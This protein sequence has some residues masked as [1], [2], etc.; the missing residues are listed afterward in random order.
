MKKLLLFVALCVVKLTYAQTLND[1]RSVATGAWATLTTWETYDGT[2]WVAATVVPTATSAQAINIRTGH[3]VTIAAAIAGG[4]DQTTVDAGGTL[5]TSGTIALSVANGTGVDLTI[6]GTFGDL[7]TGG[8]TFTGTWQMGANGTFIKTTGSSSNNWQNAYQGGII[9]IPATAFWILRK[10][11]T[12]NPALST[13]T[14]TT[15]A[16]YPNLTIENNTGAAWT[17]PAGSSFT[18]TTTR[19]TVKGNLDIGG[20]GSNTV[21]FLSSN[22]F[23]LCILVQGNVTI[24]AGCNFRN[25]G[26]GIEIQGNLTA[27]GSM[28]YDAADGRQL[29]FSGSNTQ[30]VSGTGALGIY[31]LVLNKTG[32]GVTLNRSITVDNTATFTSGIV[33][34]TSTN[35][36][37]CAA[38]CI[39]SGAS[40][41]SFVSGPVRYLGNST[42]IYPIGKGSSYRPAEVG[43]YTSA[44]W[45]ET[46]NNGCSANCAATGYTGINGTWTQTITGTEGADPNP[47]YVSCAEN[48]YTAGGC[49]TGC[50]GASSTATLASLH[51]GSAASV[52]GDAGAAYFSGG[53]CGLLACPTTDRRIESPTINCTGIVNPVVS[54]TYIENGSGTTDNA[55][56]WYFDGSTWAQIADM[57]K[58]SLCGVQGLWT[59]FSIA[60]PG[61]ASNNANVKIGFRW[62]NNDDGVGTDPSFAV[63]NLTVG[64][65]EYFTAE[66]FPANPQ[67]TFN[68]VLAPTIDA[69]SSC[70]YWII[71]RAPGTTVSATVRLS[72][73]TASCNVTTP[74]DMLVARFDGAVWQDHGNGGTTGNSISGTVVSA[75]AVTSFSPFTLATIPP[76][77]LPVQWL[78]FTA[79]CVNARAQLHWSTASEEN[80]RGFEVLRSTDGSEFLPIGFVNG[81]GSSSML[82]YYEFTD[83]QTP[84]GMVYYRLRQTDYNGQ[85]ELSP[86]VAVNTTDCAGEQL[87]LTTAVI[88]DGQMLIGWNGAQHNVTAE[89][90]T[91]D[92]A[93]LHRS[94]AA[95]G[96]GF[97]Q[98][99]LSAS[100]GIYI[101]RLND[102]VSSVSKKI[103]R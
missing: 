37:I 81:N 93:L 72:W 25:Y 34:S 12:Q 85:W 28:T 32:G 42:F 6:N 89:L 11:G 61:S 7:S 99:P 102:G 10:I 100:S 18:G 65:T 84:Q 45:T 80:N 98:I 1:Y 63:D 101:V 19:A 8:V 50:V 40:N 82:H 33:T 15:G 97:L 103:I 2:A 14:P 55:T 36:F 47:W 74:G 78:S 88:T 83:E 96:N 57:P 9:N 86:V 90:F 27:N 35:L 49:G 17:T 53:F 13:T 51:V 69:I 29:L 77:P 73:S 95:A 44:L 67:T 20:S 60:L 26:T 62:V 5:N 21:D 38:T 46:F 68:N 22:T 4:I 71:D 41:L 52:L 91:A 3:T 70:E 76:T 24:R 23:S 43:A 94:F 79:V 66:Y 48:G 59:A 39:V 92:G 31:A 54:F 75:A 87:S 56:L 58:T 64:L 30:T 16:V